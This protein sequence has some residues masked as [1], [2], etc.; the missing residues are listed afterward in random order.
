ME[1]K[2]VKSMIDDKSLDLSDYTI[3]PA[4]IVFMQGDD[5]NQMESELNESDSPDISVWLSDDKVIDY[6]LQ[7]Y[8][9]DDDH[10]YMQDKYNADDINTEFLGYLVD[11]DNTAW[12]YSLNTSIGYAGLSKIISINLK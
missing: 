6:L 4:N 2:T 11:I 8:Q 3:T 10:F 1:Y 7:W 12:L 5:Y 9:N